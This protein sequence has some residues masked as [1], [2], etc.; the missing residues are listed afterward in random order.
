MAIIDMATAD[1]Q[2]AYAHTMLKANTTTD[3]GDNVGI[4]T[5][6]KWLKTYYDI[7]PDDSAAW[8]DADIDA[9]EIGVETA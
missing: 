2:D 3:L 5:S 4:E 6:A 7:N 8:E 9:L 1:L